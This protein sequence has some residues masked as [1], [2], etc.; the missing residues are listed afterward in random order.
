[1]LTIF[2]GMAFV[3]AILFVVCST[4]LRTNDFYYHWIYFILAYCA[5][6]CESGAVILSLYI[7]MGSPQESVSRFLVYVKKEK[8]ANK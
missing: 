8:S 2:L 3:V 4:F 1:M 5:R 6:V 7:S